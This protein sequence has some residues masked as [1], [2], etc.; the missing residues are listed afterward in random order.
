MK[1]HVFLFL[2]M[3]WSALIFIGDLYNFNPNAFWL[4][5]AGG[6]SYTIGVIFYSLPKIKYFH[7][8]WHIF[9]GLGT[10][11]QFLAIYLYIY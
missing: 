11:L 2:L 4:I 8:I 1:L 6:I 5:L 7:F 3:G 10:I 9:T